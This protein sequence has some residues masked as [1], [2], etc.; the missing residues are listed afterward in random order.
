MT[1]ET[2]E[3]IKE[4]AAPVDPR[5]QARRIEVKRQA[6]QRRL[7]ILVMV[8][9]A[10][11][12]VLLGW[13]IAESPL[14]S[15]HKIQVLG[16][17]HESVKQIQTVAGI[18]RGTPLLRLPTSSIK[19]RVA[20]LPWIDTV[21]VSRKWPNK[22]RIIV[23][24][25][26]PVAWVQ[27]HH[28]EFALVDS[29]GRVLEVQKATPNGLPEL[30][31]IGNVPDPGGNVQHAEVAGVPNHLP[32]ELRPRVTKVTWQAGKLTLGL[33][34]G[35]EIRTGPSVDRKTSYSFEPV[36]P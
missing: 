4:P 6:G 16:A 28:S 18:N 23:T 2:L 11:F 13:F 29:S 26:S 20:A 14:L 5:L 3:E 34:D 25:R 27:V 15:V 32:A 22:I 30:I 17:Q 33:S 8:L 24:E 1:E 35:P 7:R 10:A 19:N 31:G 36:L 9:I 12:L 21:K